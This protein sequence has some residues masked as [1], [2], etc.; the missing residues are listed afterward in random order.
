MNPQATFHA[1]GHRALVVLSGDMSS[2]GR[3]EPPVNQRYR[4][5]NIQRILLCNVPVNLRSV[6]RR[7]T[8]RPKQPLD[9]VHQPGMF[10]ALA[11]RR[12][13]I[14]GKSRAACLS[15]AQRFIDQLRAVGT[16]PGLL[17]QF[18]RNA[19]CG[20]EYRMK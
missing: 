19:L 1:S 3:I 15:E 4:C 5:Q 9:K 11:F 10:V 8:E 16:Q 14:E 18:L 7:V 12:Q 17:T 2:N 20:L 6:S 13:R